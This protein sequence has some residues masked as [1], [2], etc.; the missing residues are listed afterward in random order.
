MG[1]LDKLIDTIEFRTQAQNLLLSD[2]H[3][4]EIELY[5]AKDKNNYLESNHLRDCI[6]RRKKDII[7]IEQKRILKKLKEIKEKDKI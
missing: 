1:E 6:K 2:I 3:R 4:L 7:H 5:W